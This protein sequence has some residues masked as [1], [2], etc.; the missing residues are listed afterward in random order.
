M[1]IAIQ[2]LHNQLLERTTL[3][4]PGEVVAWFG[5][6]QAQDWAGAKWSLGLRLPGSTDVDIEQSMT[7]KAFVRTWALRGTLHFVAA[8]DL[9]WLL[10]LISPR[11]ISNFQKRYLD[12]GLGEQT[13]ARSNALLTAALQDGK[14]LNRTALLAILEQKS[15]S[16]QGLR[17]AFLLQRAALDGLICQGVTY[18]NNPTYMSV[19]ESLPSVKK[20]EHGDA[21]V[22]LAMRYF[23]SH[24]PATLQDFTWWSGLTSK[25]AKDGLSGVQSQLIHETIDGRIYWLSPNMTANEVDC[26]PNIYLLP[27]YDEYLVS[28][29]DR[30]ASL[31]PLD[32]GN[33]NL[34]NGLSPTIIKNGQVVGTWQRRYKK[35]T[36]IIKA[37]LFSPLTASEKLAFDAAIHLYEEFLG[38]PVQAEPS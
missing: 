5:A 26:S 14:Q 28:Y 2:R 21:L 37:N 8:S 18:R 3:H 12:L 17:A 31:Y 9:R 34:A 1:E 11:I 22:M 36:V 35:E 25:E 30:S 4:H 15:I 10:A 38:V 6:I 16:T 24:G 13:L 33:V 23:T 32:K 7:S 19:E 29:K 27:G 20:M